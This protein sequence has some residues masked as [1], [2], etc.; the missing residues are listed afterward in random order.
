MP[1]S[2][3][4]RGIGH[5][6]WNTTD[7]Q[8][9]VHAH[10]LHREPCPRARSDHSIHRI[11]GK[12]VPVARHYRLACQSIPQSPGNRADGQS[13]HRPPTH[14]A[15]ASAAVRSADWPNPAEQLFNV[16]SASGLSF[17]RARQ[18]AASD[19]GVTDAGSS[20]MVSKNWSSSSRLVPLRKFSNS[21]TSRCKGKARSRVKSRSERRACCKNA[22]LDNVLFIGAYMFLNDLRQN[23][24][25]GGWNGGYRVHFRLL[26]MVV[27]RRYFTTEQ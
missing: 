2:P 20:V 8:R 22:S 24:L 14:A 6:A 3:G 12:S 26:E 23:S 17:F 15:P 16:T 27:N 4:H 9:P 11:A 18:K 1:G 25:I 19:T 7:T 21:G 10:P 13:N 5:P